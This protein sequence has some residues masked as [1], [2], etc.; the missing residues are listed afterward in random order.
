[1]KVMLANGKLPPLPQGLED[2]SNKVQV[3]I[4]PHRSIHAMVAVMQGMAQLFSIIGIAAVH[5]ATARPFLTSDT[6]ILWFD[7]SIPFSEQR[8]YTI[9]VDG[10]P[11]LSSEERR[12]GTECGSTCR[13]RWSRYHK[14]KKK[15]N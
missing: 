13:D 5:N 4:D 12:V 1:M 9:N 11:V 7:P 14:Q 6:P 10:G 15:K 8:P 3:S 2:L